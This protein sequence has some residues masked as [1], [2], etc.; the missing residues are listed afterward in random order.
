V[1]E[2]VPVAGRIPSGAWIFFSG[3]NDRSNN[4][5]VSAGLVFHLGDRPPDPRMVVSWLSDTE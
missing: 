2:P 1:N 5:R 4:L 3:T